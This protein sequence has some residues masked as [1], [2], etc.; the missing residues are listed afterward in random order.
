MF[1]KGGYFLG[2]RLIVVFI[3]FEHGYMMLYD[4]I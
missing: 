1:W 3:L 2:D 4:V